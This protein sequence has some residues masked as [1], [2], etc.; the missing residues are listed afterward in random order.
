[1]SFCCLQSHSQSEAHWDGD[2]GLP[3]SQREGYMM[4]VLME[5]NNVSDEEVLQ[6]LGDLSTS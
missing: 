2:C 4:Q 3:W 1:M 5:D 6:G